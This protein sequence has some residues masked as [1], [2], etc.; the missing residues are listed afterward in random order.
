MVNWRCNSFRY[1]IHSLFRGISDLL[2]TLFFSTWICGWPNK[3]H[4][5]LSSNTR[6]FFNKE[7]TSVFGNL[8]RHSM[9]NCNF[10]PYIF[11]FSS[12]KINIVFWENLEKVFVEKRICD[13]I[14]KRTFVTRN[15]LYRS[16]KESWISKFRRR[17]LNLATRYIA[18]TRN[19]FAKYLWTGYSWIRS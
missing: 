17:C 3:I 19:C 8:E 10:A 16:L 1:L 11:C 6:F 13:L 15:I 9:D 18:A 2:R 12:G 4:S 7:R 5:A 14:M